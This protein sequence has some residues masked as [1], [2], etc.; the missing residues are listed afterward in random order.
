MRPDGPPVMMIGPS[1][2]N[3]P[4]EPMEIADEI[5]FQDRQFRLHFAAVDENGFDRFGNTV[6]ADALRS[7]SRHQT[8]DQTT[9]IGTSTDQYP[10]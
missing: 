3:G 4:P 2:P 5:G 9:P 7:V 6:T 10:R 8:D 1:A